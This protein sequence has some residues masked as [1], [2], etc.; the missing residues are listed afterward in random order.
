[1]TLEISVS[2]IFIAESMSRTT[3]GVAVA[4]SI[5]TGALN[6]LV[7]MPT[8]LYAGRKSDPLETTMLL[9]L[10]VMHMTEVRLLC[11]SP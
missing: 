6:K 9:L 5:R 4:V 7:T 1:M 10:S 8:S 3:L 2:F 11:F